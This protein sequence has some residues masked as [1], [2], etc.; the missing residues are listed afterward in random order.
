MKRNLW[1]CS[2]N[3]SLRWRLWQG[4]DL[5]FSEAMGLLYSSSM[6]DKDY[7]TS[8][9]ADTA[10]FTGLHSNCSLQSSPGFFDL[11]GKRKNV[12]SMLRSNSRKPTFNTYVPWRFSVR[13]H[14][15]MICIIYCPTAVSWSKRCINVWPLGVPWSYISL[16]GY[17]I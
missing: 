1:E 3:I 16:R 8:H 14:N 5:R 15:N 2:C 9:F 17:L 11:A 10:S 7:I 13:P 12:G 6:I 4:V